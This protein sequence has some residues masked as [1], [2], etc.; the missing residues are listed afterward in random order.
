MSAS[1]RQQDQDESQTDSE[2][3]KKPRLPEGDNKAVSDLIPA[4]SDAKE[5]KST[6]GELKPPDSN[7][8]SVLDS[9]SELNKVEDVKSN[10]KKVKRR[11]VVLLLSYSGW[12]YFG[13][14]R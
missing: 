11:K 3:V 4:C 14:Q 10:D 12:G 8:V 6:D 13:M 5:N 2:P 9:A 7:A 1:K